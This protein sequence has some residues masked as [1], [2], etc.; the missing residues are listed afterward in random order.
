[1]N[2]AITA[3][4]GGSG[5]ES[6]VLNQA[7]IEYAGWKPFSNIAPLR[8][9]VGAWATP[10][11]L[12]DATSNTEQLFLERAAPA[13]IV[14]NIAGGDGRSGVGIFANSDH[15]YGSAVFTGSTVG[16]TGEFDE[17][18]GYLLRVAAE[19]IQGDGYGPHLGANVSGVIDPADT[20]AGV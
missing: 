18:T 11:G 10:T 7:Y 5:S 4:F 6:P 8:F 20:N 13:Q 14:R 16:N 9:R 19:P 1:W 12:E 15:Y 3:E 17:Q 2:Y